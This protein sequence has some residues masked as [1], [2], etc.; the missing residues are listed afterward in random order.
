MDSQDRS[1]WPIQI[2]PPNCGCTEC[3]IGQYVPI[4][5][6]TSR[7]FDRF[8]AGVVS[9]ASGLSDYDFDQYCY[10]TV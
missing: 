1:N 5:H 2:D 6:A 7:D 9:D 4:N 8:V 3:L 10:A